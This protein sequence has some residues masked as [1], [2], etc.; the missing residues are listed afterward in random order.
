MSRTYNLDEWRIWEQNACP[1]FLVMTL[2]AGMQELR[3][4]FGTGLWTTVIIFEENQGRWLFRPKE[5]KLLG[6]KM[7]DFLLCLP[8]R[9]AFFTGYH[10]AEQAVLKKAQEIQFSIDFEALS[11]EDLVTLFEDFCHI[12]YSWYKYGWF[13]EPVQFQS[14]DLLTAWLEKEVKAGKLQFS[15]AELR[16]V[17]FTI[18]EDTFAVEIL[19]HLSECARALG[20]TLK[21]DSLAKAV[22]KVIGDADK[23]AQIT[24]QII[25]SNSDNEDFRLLVDKIKE[26]SLKF[27]WKRNNYFATQFV[28]EKDILLE[29]FGSEK[30]DVSNPALQ[31]EN[32][33]ENVQKSKKEALSKKSALLEVLPPYYRNLVAL[34]S[35]VGGSL[36]DRRKKVIMIVNGAFDKILHVIAKRTNHAIDDCRFLIPQ[37]LGEFV[38]SP[39]GYRHRFKERKVR[40]LVFQGDFPLVEEL[41]GDV[42]SMA[43]KSELNYKAFS[44]TEPFIAEGEQADKVLERLNSR[45]NYL[46]ESEVPL[47]EKLQGIVTYY[48]PNEPE[49]TGMVTVIK[50]PKVETL[51]SGEILVAPSTTPDYMDAIRKC[52]AIVTDWGGQ[53]SH[54]AIVSRELRKPCVIGTNYA[55]HVLR[56]GD[57]V[58]IDLRQ[59]VIEIMK[60]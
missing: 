17:I 48:D 13:C 49:V 51:K 50:N 22:K 26:H 54:A 39:E 56:N 24:L 23:G 53:T 7:I 19:R 21:N 45:L 60:A 1:M 15:I 47:T 8:Y 16:Q 6:Q 2:N 43:A 28:T 36:I 20:R 44:M 46:A 9:V 34:V 30:F 18:E 33:I 25:E 38:S 11:D 4:Y 42:T 32:E 31:F 58:K 52:R 12:Y 5:L 3:D 59:G 10:N 29:I 57:K 37:E 35:S 41:F 27:Y 14:Q 55:S 40:F